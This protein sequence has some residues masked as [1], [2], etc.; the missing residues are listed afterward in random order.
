MNDKKNNTFNIDEYY[1]SVDK[2]IINE[3]C[4]NN[5]IKNLIY[6]S[7]QTDLNPFNKKNK[8]WQL[9]SKDKLLKECEQVKKKKIKDLSTTLSHLAKLGNNN[10]QDVKNAY[11]NFEGKLENLE[12]II[13]YVNHIDSNNIIPIPYDNNKLVNICEPNI[14]TTNIKTTYIID[15]DANSQSNLVSFNIVGGY[16]KNNPKLNIKEE[17]PA[18]IVK[19]NIINN[20][21]TASES[22][23]NDYLECYGNC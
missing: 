12:K 11:K 9:K 21:K 23:D 7:Y 19:L 1:A 22:S 3:L 6:L 10:F 2:N 8:K 15:H 14:K 16:N 18:K 4:T 13:D 20:I 5:N 17:K